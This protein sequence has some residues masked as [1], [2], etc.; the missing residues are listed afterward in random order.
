M[1]KD[2]VD[3]VLAR[4]ESLERENRRLRRWGAGAAVL[5]LALGAAGLVA[6]QDAP[7]TVRAQ[8]LE[9]VDGKGTV[10][11]TF[12]ATDAGPE[13]V[14]RDSGGGRKV[15][16]ATPAGDLTGLRVETPEFEVAAGALGDRAHLG[17]RG[18]SGNR[19]V[20]TV[21]EDDG[22]SLTL[23]HEGRRIVLQAG[24]V[25]GLVAVQK[26]KG[27]AAMGFGHDGPFLRLKDGSGKAVFEAPK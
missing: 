1:P 6:P 3:A 23:D 22:P 9:I 12:A 19:S 21:L 11:G 17:M 13:L 25:M 2:R 26:E 18:R 14:L 10:L 16:L 27:G 5:A 15:T 4:M 7:G 24:A 20:R 8:R